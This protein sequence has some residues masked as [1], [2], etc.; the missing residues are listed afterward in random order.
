MNSL[1]KTMPKLHQLLTIQCS[2]PTSSPLTKSKGRF[3]AMRYPYPG[4]QEQRPDFNSSDF[5]DHKVLCLIKFLQNCQLGRLIQGVFKREFSLK[6]LQVQQ[7]T[8]LW[9]MCWELVPLRVWNCSFHA[10][11]G[12]L[13][14]LVEKAAKIKE[15]SRLLSVVI[16]WL[17]Y[18]TNHVNTTTFSDQ[19]QALVQ[20][21]QPC[22][23]CE[24]NAIINRDA[25]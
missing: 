17:E 11:W 13:E 4:P 16:D 3:G 5:H 22:I 12:K 14:N 8:S 1:V 25:L 23:Q 18:D 15:E 21:Q 7:Q 20:L 6:A 24:R 19:T 10:I 2:S 9:H